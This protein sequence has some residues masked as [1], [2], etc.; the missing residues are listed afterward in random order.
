MEWEQIEGFTGEKPWVPHAQFKVEFS[1]DVTTKPVL[2]CKVDLVGAEQPNK[3]NIDLSLFQ[4]TA[5]YNY[6]LK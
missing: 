3:F 4:G 5:S 6:G 1:G 2:T